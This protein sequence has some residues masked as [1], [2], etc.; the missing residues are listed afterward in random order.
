[1]ILEEE[2]G[3][4]LGGQGVHVSPWIHQEYTSETE[5][6]AEHQLRVGRNT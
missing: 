5:V 2:D 6:L 1:M 3:R 4:E